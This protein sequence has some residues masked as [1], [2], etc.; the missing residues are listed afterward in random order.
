MEAKIGIKQDDISQVAHILTRI[1]ADEY[2][3]YTKTSQVCI[4]VISILGID[5]TTR[6]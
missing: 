2:V 4:N 6:T 5:T 1:L 3:L